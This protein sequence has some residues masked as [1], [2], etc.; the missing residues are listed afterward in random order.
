LWRLKDVY[1]QERAIEKGVKKPELLKAPKAK[2]MAV[3]WN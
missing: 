2:K 1:L 3:K